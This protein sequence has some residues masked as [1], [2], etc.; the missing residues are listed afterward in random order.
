MEKFVI[1]CVMNY[2]WR[3]SFVWISNRQYYKYS[4]Q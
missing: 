2:R 4:R 1:E 3:V